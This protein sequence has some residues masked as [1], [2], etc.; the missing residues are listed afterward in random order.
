M[1]FRDKIKLVVK[2]TPIFSEYTLA[3]T[4]KSF[5]EYADLKFVSEDDMNPFSLSSQRFLG[6]FH[7]YYGR[8]FSVKPK[9]SFFRKDTLS[10]SIWVHGKVE[11]KEE[12]GLS[13][14]VTYHRTDFAKYG[15]WVLAGTIGFMFLIISIRTLGN[16]DFIN[17]L[18]FCGALIFFYL[19]GTLIS[20]AQSNGQIAYFEKHFIDEI[21]KK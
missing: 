2:G 7:G 17:F 13:L 16:A 15:Q 4:E 5:K 14:K 21:R 8:E 6:H 19:F 20:I 10:N 11:P 12:K 18:I 1:T 9:S 3:L